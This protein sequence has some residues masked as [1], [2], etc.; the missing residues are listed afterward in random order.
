MTQTHT[1]SKHRA[2]DLL[3]LALSASG[4]PEIH[5]RVHSRLVFPSHLPTLSLPT[6][7]LQTPPPSHLPR[8]QSMCCLRATPCAPVPHRSAAPPRRCTGAARG[9]ARHR[10]RRD[11][12][13]LDAV[14]GG[15]AAALGLGRALLVRV[16]VRVRVRVGV[17]VGVRVR[18][19]VRVGVRV[20]VSEPS[21][22]SPMGVPSSLSPRN[23][24][25]P[26]QP[27]SRAW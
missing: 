1:V 17:R 10:A 18:V 21:S 12:R 7:S 16:R 4:S 6:Q 14:H 2:V 25:S 13:R 9:A 22:A 26:L 23:D 15:L 20:R 19:R 5:A 11:D 3:Y 24:M 27:S 8:V